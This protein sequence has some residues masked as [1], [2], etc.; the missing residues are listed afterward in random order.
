MFLLDSFYIFVFI[1]GE[2]VIVFTAP[3][4]VLVG[5]TVDELKVEGQEPCHSTKD[6]VV[7]QAEQQREYSIARWA[8]YMM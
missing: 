7:R 4:V 3:A 5:E 8:I 1:P 2:H 6:P